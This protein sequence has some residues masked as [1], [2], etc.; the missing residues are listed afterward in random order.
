MKKFFILITVFVMCLSFANTKADTLYSVSLSAPKYAEIGEEFEIDI[1]I[2]TNG[3][4]IYGVEFKISYDPLCY[5]F[6]DSKP[7]NAPQDTM[8]NFGIS[9]EAEGILLCCSTDDMK[10]YDN[11]IWATVKF[12]VIGSKIKKTSFACVPIENSGFI[13]E[14]FNLIEN[15]NVFLRQR[16]YVLQLQVHLSKCNTYC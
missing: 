14:A 10:S 1:M 16:R 8:L 12:R 15:E 13:D 7:I 6:V 3:N 9:E 11:V 5:E 4:K 2:N